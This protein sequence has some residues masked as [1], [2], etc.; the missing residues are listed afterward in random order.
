LPNG[1]E[2]LAKP[3]TAHTLLWRVRDALGRHQPAT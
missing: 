1:C 3:F 2:M